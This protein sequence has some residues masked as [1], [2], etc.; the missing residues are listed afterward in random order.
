MPGEYR[1]LLLMGVMSLL[2]PPVEAQTIRGVVVDAGVTVQ[3]GGIETNL[4]IAGA[5]VVLLPGGRRE[6]TRTL[7]DSL[8]SFRFSL[9]GGGRYRLSVSHPAFYPYETEGLEVG[10]EEAVS[11]EIRLG[12]NVLPL[13]PLVVVARTNTTLAGFHE[14]RTTGGF[15]TYL[16][17]EEIQARGTTRTTD[18]LRGLP[19]IRI[20]FVRW[21]VGPTIEMQSSFGPCEPTIFVD[22]VQAPQLSS[23]SLNDF[24]L[25]DLIEGVEVYSSF[26]SAPAQ[27]TSGI[28]GSILFWTRRGGREGGEPWS[29]KRVLLGI[30]AAAGLILW[31]L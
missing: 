21:G 2:A 31:I 23:S 7:T 9:P 20:Q 13:D 10:R 26:S 15:G 30:G 18:L 11:V 25:V 24:L 29:W 4:P 19:G 12:R 8:G 6:G 16:T 28:C 17:R 27:Y 22:G 14:R 1:T 5:E 3:S